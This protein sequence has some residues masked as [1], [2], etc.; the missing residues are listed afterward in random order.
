MHGNATGVM[1]HPSAICVSLGIASRRPAV[2]AR[3]V[4]AGVDHVPNPCP[5]GGLKCPSY[6][7]PPMNLVG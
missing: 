4:H 3:S 1:S 5:M 7:D 2:K 6:L